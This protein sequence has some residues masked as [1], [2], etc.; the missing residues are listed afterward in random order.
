M[1][2]KVNLPTRQ[3]TIGNILNMTELYDKPALGVIL[4]N[5]DR[6]ICETVVSFGRIMR[7]GHFAYLRQKGRKG[8]VKNN[9]GKGIG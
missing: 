2:G 8:Q 1:D 3:T 9:S 7:P 6:N 5:L 4:Y